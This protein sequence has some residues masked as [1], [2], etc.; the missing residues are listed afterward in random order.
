MRKIFLGAPGS[1]KGTAASRV[2]PRFNIPHIS[3]GDLF[4]QN[5][6]NETPIGMEAKGYM[7]R[8]ELVPDEI[9][10]GM[11][12]DRINEDDCKEGFILD[13][14]PRT[15]PQAE[16]LAELSDMDVVINMD[17][18]DDIVIERLSSRVT[19]KD[20]GEIFNL[21]GLIPKKEGQC[22]KCEGDLI[23][24]LDDE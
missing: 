9:V 12:A 20:C 24:R 23:R 5:I 17:V 15:I 8:G 19:C 14:F 18:S 2:A 11:L 16:K 22:D 21:R 7:E 3:T 4:R 10:I 1:G 13:G 6:K